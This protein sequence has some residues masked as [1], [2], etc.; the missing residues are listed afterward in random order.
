MTKEDKQLVKNILL[1]ANKK[2][3]ER[4]EDVP[5]ADHP[6]RICIK[7]LDENM[8]RQDVLVHCVVESIDD[9]VTELLNIVCPET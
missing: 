8:Q 5:L 6:H 7:G 1:H 3:R 4:Y 2:T 9:I